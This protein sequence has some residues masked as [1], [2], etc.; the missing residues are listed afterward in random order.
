MRNILFYLLTVLIW[1]SSW[2]GIKF[3]LDSVDPM[4]S[5]A[6][7]FALA[8]V[9]LLAWCMLRGLNLRY[10][11]RAHVFMALQGGLLFGFNYLFFYIAELR[12]TSGL[13]AVMFSTILIMNILNGALFLRKPI[14]KKVVIGGIFGLIGITLVFKPEIQSFSFE[15]EAIQGILLC[16]IATF[17]A[18][19]G[20][21]VSAYNQEHKLPI[22]QTNA[23]GMGYGAA[24]MFLC[25]IVS[26]KTFSFDFSTSYI[27]S[28]LFL[29]IFASIIA[30]GCYLSLVGEIGP[31]RAAYA[32]L[33][34]PI[35]A[36]LISTVW[37]G[38]EWTGSA[39]TGFVLILC[40]NLFILKRKKGK[41][42]SQKEPEDTTPLP[43]KSGVPVNIEP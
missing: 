11:K 17:S 3:Q 2:I 26:G 24:I 32:T 12:I 18:S 33:L 4:V 42:T 13:A 6:Y 9:L 16:L 38:Y 8:S 40:G 7:R 39:I 43:L 20:N 34:F 21:I 27:V 25:A 41:T 15:S 5:V 35:V 22:I 36:L 23:I 31:D 29:A 30:F 28:L 10:S 37:E 19:L 1:G 14:D